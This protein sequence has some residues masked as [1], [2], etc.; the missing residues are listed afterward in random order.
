MSARRSKSGKPADNPVDKK[1][2]A[3]WPARAIEHWPI[4]RLRPFERNSRVHSPDQVAQVAQA[5]EHWGWTNPVLCGDDGKIIAGHC[6][7]LAAKSLG[8]VEVPVIVA[9]GWSDEQKRAYV[10]ADNRLQEEGRWDDG[11]LSIEL[12]DL[13]DAGFDLSL[14][15]MSD[16]DLLRLGNDGDA[17]VTVR[18][19]ATS[20][21][22]DE[23]WISVRG[24]LSHQADALQRLSEV[25]REF[26]GV[27]VELGTIG[28]EP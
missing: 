6:R 26:K 27:S 8:I 9:R 4:S 17:E 14:T 16:D 2:E 10:I 23:F 18:E 12:S 3:D 1:R 28:I 25:M 7:V 22:N 24:P 13:A 19:I 11:L 20:P 15:G 21:V 5:I